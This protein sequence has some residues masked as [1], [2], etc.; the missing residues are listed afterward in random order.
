M[1]RQIVMNETLMSIIGPIESTVELVSPDGQL[2]GVVLPAE[3][4]YDPVIPPPPTPEEL[5]RL[6]A[7]P[8]CSTAELLAYL[9]SL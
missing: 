9:R 2:M 7:E 3:D 1:R 6:R 4:G 5:E 8:D